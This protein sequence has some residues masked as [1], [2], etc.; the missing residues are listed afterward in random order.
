MVAFAGAAAG[1]DGSPGAAG[2]GAPD[3]NG[4]LGSGGGDA[5]SPPSAFPQ[6][7]QEI[8]VGQLVIAQETEPSDGWWEAIVV[9]V[10]GDAL[11]L[12][13]RDYPKLPKIK[14]HR[15]AVALLKPSAQ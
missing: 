9:A 13:W 4:G 10:D 14:R 11:I 12:Q 7:W 15:T 1:S 6:N 2:S 8:A 3:G 5:N